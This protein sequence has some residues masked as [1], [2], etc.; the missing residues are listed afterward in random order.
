MLDRD[1]TNDLLVHRISVI[2]CIILISVLS[3][4][5]SVFGCTT[6]LCILTYFKENTFLNHFSISKNYSRVYD[7]NPFDEKTR[8]TDYLHGLK[9]ALVAGSILT[10]CFGVVIFQSPLLFCKCLHILSKRFKLRR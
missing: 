2:N 7:Y 3:L 9:S 1:L 6:A 5:R 10:H 4:C 8:S